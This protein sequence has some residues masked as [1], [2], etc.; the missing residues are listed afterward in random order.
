MQIGEMI[1]IVSR[2][3]REFE[4]TTKCSDNGAHQA[5][6]ELEHVVPQAD[7]HELCIFSALLD[8]VRHDR[9]VL[10]I[11]TSPATR[12]TQSN[13]DAEARGKLMNGIGKRIFA[14]PEGFGVIRL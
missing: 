12:S 7:D 1:N 5:V 9:H 14:Q 10:E 4:E 13:G 2:A 6:C 8:V 3:S 11:C